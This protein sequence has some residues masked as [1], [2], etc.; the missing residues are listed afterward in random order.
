MHGHLGVY[1][2]FPRSIENAK[3]DAEA[4]AGAGAEAEDSSEMPKEKKEPN[5]WNAL[6]TQTVSEMKQGGWQS[7]TDLKGVVWPGSRLGK[8]KDKKGAET[9]SEQQVYDG[10]EHDGKPP[11]PALG[12]MVRAS[13]LKSLT[14]PEAKA[15]AIKYHAK[16]DEKRSVGSGAAEEP[17]AD[18]P[19][20]GKPRGKMTEEAKVAAKIK[21][22]L[23]LTHAKKAADALTVPRPAFVSA[24]ASVAEAEEFEDIPEA[25]TTPKPSATESK[26]APTPAPAPA[27]AAAASKA[28]PKPKVVKAKTVDL[29]FRIWEHGGNTYV[30]NERGDVLSD[31]GSEWVGRF[32]GNSID[33]TVAEPD[34]LGETRIYGEDE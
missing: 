23:G 26:P 9:G 17:V 20:A 12:G 14:D 27:A 3:T 8:V 31:D 13:Y 15:K 24:S 4:E 30:K 32:S 18:A 21:R 11:S 16:L 33:E 1:S 10:G 2:I 7:W 28:K 34:D 22:E 6:V 5:A 19:G 25:S 29:N